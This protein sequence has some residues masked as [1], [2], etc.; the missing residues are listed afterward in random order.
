MYFSFFI[1]Y[2]WVFF[3]NNNN[4]KT[5]LKLQLHEATYNTRLNG[6]YFEFRENN[7]MVW[8]WSGAF[9]LHDYVTPLQW[10]SKKKREREYVSERYFLFLIL[11][12]WS[13]Y[14]IWFIIE[15]FVCCCFKV[16]D[17][18]F[19]FIFTNFFFFYSFCVC[20]KSSLWKWLIYWFFFIK[21]KAHNFAMLK[22]TN[23]NNVSGRG[24]CMHL[25]Y[26]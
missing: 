16:F 24:E 12:L 19:K 3:L 23:T 11:W 10:A 9:C 15:F 25:L 2:Y 6:K 20:V 8:E 4:N 13:C 17:Y 7:H 26:L 22:K 5:K 1:N 18:F 14:N 21:Q